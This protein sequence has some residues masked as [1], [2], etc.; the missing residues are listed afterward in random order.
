LQSEVLE[1][2]KLAAD[3][4]DKLQDIYKSALEELHALDRLWTSTHKIGDELLALSSKL[5]YLTRWMAQLEE[6]QF[7]LSIL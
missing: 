4:V 6:R 3:L 2:R 5:A 7:Q 1:K